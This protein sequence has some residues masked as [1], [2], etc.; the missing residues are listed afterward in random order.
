MTCIGRV[1]EPELSSLVEAVILPMPVKTSMH[2]SGVKMTMLA[3]ELPCRLV[4]Q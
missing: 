2:P 4:T 3:K 1:L